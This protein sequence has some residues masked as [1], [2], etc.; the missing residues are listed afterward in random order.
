MSAGFAFAT[1]MPP[2]LQS[3]C[4][5]SGYSI[6]K[7]QGQILLQIFPRVLFHQRNVKQIFF[8]ENSDVDNSSY[9]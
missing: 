5:H 3:F 2:Q 8:K 4:F 1:L 6:Y 9:H 7:A